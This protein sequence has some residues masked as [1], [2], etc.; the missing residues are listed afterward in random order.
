MYN[1]DA[2]EMRMLLWLG[3]FGGIHQSV[4]SVSSW[5]QSSDMLNSYEDA[6]DTSG[7]PLP[8]G[9]LP[10]AGA[11][12]LRLCVRQLLQDPYTGALR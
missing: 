3:P 2:N 5:N 8:G 10:G 1:R 11:V 4:Q 12:G 6:D 7:L 9:S